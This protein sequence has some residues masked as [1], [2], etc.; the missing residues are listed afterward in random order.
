MK[1]G[2]SL[3]AADSFVLVLWEDMVYKS[4]RS[5]IENDCQQY[6][7]VIATLREEPSLVAFT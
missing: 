1:E 7:T 6:C 4:Y 5:V 2:M 3:N